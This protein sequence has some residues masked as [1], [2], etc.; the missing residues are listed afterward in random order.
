MKPKPRKEDSKEI[1]QIRRMK[2]LEGIIKKSDI[3]NAFVVTT[4]KDSETVSSNIADNI[5]N[6]LSGERINERELST[7]EHITMS[8][9]RSGKAADTAA[10]GA[11]QVHLVKQRPKRDHVTERARKHAAK[12][13]QRKASPKKKGIK[14][15]TR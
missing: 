11:S 3:E 4:S 6:K 9:G 8:E 15:R 7:I 14:K 2:E 5:I 1:E 12:P 10:G 13:K